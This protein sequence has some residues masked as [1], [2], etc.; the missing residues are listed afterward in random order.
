MAAAGQPI[1]SRMTE[2]RWDPLRGEWVAFASERQERTLLPPRERCP[3]CPTP[4]GGPL[5]EAPER[6]EI[7][8]FDNRFPAL[9]PDAPPPPARADLFQARAGYGF[10]EVVLYSEDHTA[11]LAHLPLR[12]LERL[13]RVWRERYLTLGAQPGVEYVYIFENRGE[14]VGVTLEHPHGQ[15]YALPFIPPIPARE[16]ALNAAARAETG[17]CLLCTIAASEWEAQERVVFAA[18]EVIVYCPFASR[19]PY[20]THLVPLRHLASLADLDTTGCRALARALGVISRA[21]DRLWQRPLPLM[22]VMHQAPTDG[23]PWPEAHLH[24]E[25]YPLARSAEKLK[26]LAGSES[27]AGL[28]VADLL[29]EQSAA[30]LRAARDPNFS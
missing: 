16:L 2:L 27:G 23:Q 30:A 15:I 26:Y 24:I 21:Y 3:F 6:Y 28:F 4:L 22:L 7:A 13:V 17:R 12:H 8:V 29:P 5:T 10:C 19:F 1:G 20:E 14:A 18:E 11:S 25:F 9:R